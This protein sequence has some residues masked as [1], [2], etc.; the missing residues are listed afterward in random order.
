MFM[1]IFMLMYVFVSTW[2]LLLLSS[3][4]GLCLLDIDR[5]LGSLECCIHNDEGVLATLLLVNNIV[6]GQAFVLE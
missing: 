3:S 2:L 1:F 4:L 6:N 5:L